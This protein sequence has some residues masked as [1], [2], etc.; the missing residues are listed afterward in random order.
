MKGNEVRLPTDGEW[1]VTTPKKERNGGFRQIQRGGL[2]RLQLV[3]VPTNRVINV[4]QSG[5]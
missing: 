4:R 5:Y 3:K 1:M 2:V